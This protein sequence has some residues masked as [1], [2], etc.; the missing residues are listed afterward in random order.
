MFNGIIFNQG[1][2]KKIFK[3]PKGINFFLQSK[4]KLKKNGRLF[5][6][7]KHMELVKILKGLKKYIVI[8]NNDNIRYRNKIRRQ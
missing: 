4:L 7:Q 8:I 6:D 3:R 1:V 5:W 2:V